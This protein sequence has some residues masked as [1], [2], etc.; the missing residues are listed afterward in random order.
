MIH[1]KVLQ[2]VETMKFLGLQLDNH[3]NCKGHI[4]FLLHK[5]STLCFL[6]RKLYHTLNINGLKTVYYAYYH[7]LVNYGIIFWGNTTDSN[8]V[9]VLQK[10]I[11]RIIMGVGPTYSCRGLFNHLEILPIPSVYLYSLMMF[12]VIILTSFN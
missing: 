11:I 6:M 4:D 7:S 8:K 12:V 2:E 10:K 5:L 3:L 9:F 1:S